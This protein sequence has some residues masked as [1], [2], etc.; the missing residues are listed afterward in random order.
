MKTKALTIVIT[1]MTLLFVQTLRAQDVQM[2]TLQRGDQLVGVYYG[3]GGL[4]QALDAAEKGD[5]ISL[6]GGPFS[7]ATIRKAVTIQGA[8][9][10]QDADN[11]R[12]RTTVTGTQWVELPEGEEGLVVEGIYFQDDVYCYDIT[13]ATF[14]K[15]RFSYLRFDNGHSVNCTVDQCRIANY[16]APDSKSEN[17]YVRN[18]IIREVRSNDVEATLL[19]DHCNVTRYVDNSL[20]AYFQNSLIKNPSTKVNCS[21]INCVLGINT[22]YSY[23]SGGNITTVNVDGT[24]VFT[25]NEGNSDF[26]PEEYKALFEN[27]DCA[28]T[29]SDDMDYRLTDAAAAQYLGNDGTQVGIYGGQTPFTSVPTNPQVTYKE[30]APQSDENGLLKVKIR[31]EAQGNGQ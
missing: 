13:N 18:S 14:R 11:F 2:A 20:T 3:G 27:P 25:G 1:M 6:S 4:S 28:F 19:F 12:Y 7:S 22:N 5:V 10:V 8:G 23:G 15:C 29:Y 31:V 9:Y 16:F 26:V 30:I 17:L 21:Y 24:T